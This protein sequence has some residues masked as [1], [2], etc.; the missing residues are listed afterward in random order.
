MIYFARIGEDGPIKIGKADDV[1]E[2]LFGLKFEF[3][4]PVFLLGVI[5]GGLEA[6]RDMHQRFC[7][8]RLESEDSSELFSP[9]PDLMRFIDQCATV[10]THT[11]RKVRLNRAVAMQARCVAKIRGVSLAEYLSEL[12]RPMVAKDFQHITRG[13]TADPGQEHGA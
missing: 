2:R 6:E 9:G 5:N 4:Q 11:L 10:Y 8:L 3:K 1:K 7:N 13:E 12:V